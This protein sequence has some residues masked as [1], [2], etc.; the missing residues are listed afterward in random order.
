MSSLCSTCPREVQFVKV[1]L[2]Q[3]MQHPSVES[4][5][6]ERVMKIMTP[7]HIDNLGKNTQFC[8]VIKWKDGISQMEKHKVLHEAGLDSEDEV[9][10][11]REGH[12]GYF[13][14]VQPC[15]NC[16]KVLLQEGFQDIERAVITYYF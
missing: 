11:K 12:K 7:R 1:V 3:L 13:K 4:V 16:Y 9:L 8:A 5:D 6:F 14:L 10:F 2:R 15:M